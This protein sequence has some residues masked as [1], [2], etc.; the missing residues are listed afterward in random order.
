MTK[1][2]DEYVDRWTEGQTEQQGYIDTLKNR[3]ID[4]WVDGTMERDRLIDECKDK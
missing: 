3:R 4:Q 1:W 2:I